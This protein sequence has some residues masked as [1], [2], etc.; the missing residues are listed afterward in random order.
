MA[1]EINVHDNFSQ[2]DFLLLVRVLWDIREK[3]AGR[4]FYRREPFSSM[5]VVTCE[6]GESA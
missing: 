5:V 2:I 4:H 3:H 1:D 6:M